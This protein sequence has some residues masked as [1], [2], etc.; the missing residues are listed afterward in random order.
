MDICERHSQ[1]H[2]RKL[3]NDLHYLFKSKSA[4]KS[5]SFFADVSLIDILKNDEELLHQ[6]SMGFNAHSNKTAS[7]SHRLCPW[8]DF[9]VQQ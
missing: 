8:L 9:K 6:Y 7:V 2:Y 5:V 4:D 1:D 3:E